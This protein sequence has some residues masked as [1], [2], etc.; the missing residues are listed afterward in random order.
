MKPA[1][2]FAFICSRSNVIAAGVVSTLIHIQKTHGAADFGG[3]INPFANSS[4]RPEK[5]APA[6]GCE[7]GEP[8]GVSTPG[9]LLRPRTAPFAKGD[10]AASEAAIVKFSRNL[11][12]F[13]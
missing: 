3:L 13:I 5:L 11:R 9:S 12:L 6:S 4:R 2:P 1:M 8:A 7:I 10:A